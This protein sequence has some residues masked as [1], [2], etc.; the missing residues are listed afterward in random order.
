MTVGEFRTKVVSNMEGSDSVRSTI[1]EAVAA[2]IGAVPGA[3]L[4]WSFEPGSTRVAVS[5]DRSVPVSVGP[6]RSKPKKK[7]PKRT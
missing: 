6:A 5:V 2:L 7:S 1:P 4:L 3:T